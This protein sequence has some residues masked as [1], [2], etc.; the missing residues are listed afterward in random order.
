M[1][2]TNKSKKYSDFIDLGV[3]LKYNMGIYRILYKSSYAIFWE[4]EFIN[5]IKETVH[6]NLLTKYIL[7]KHNIPIHL[8]FYLFKYI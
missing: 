5:L 6:R 4:R 1:A 7:C 8:Q 3:A 2:K